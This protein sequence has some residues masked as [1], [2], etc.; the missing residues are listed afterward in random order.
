ML[1]PEFT[2]LLAERLLRGESINLQGEHGTGRRQTVEELCTLLPDDLSVYRF[3]FRRDQ[4]D[5]NPWFSQSV[6]R[7]GKRLLIL[8]NF[9]ELDATKRANREF[10]ERLS[11]I[12]EQ[13][14]IP[15]LL[16]TVSLPPE[17]G[18]NIDT[19]PLPPLP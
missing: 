2:R 3:D 11:G 17:W 19:L 8:H 16:V 15:L 7:K 10:I 6:S 14:G 5:P 1:R 13:G 12:A 4:S 18:L 9:D